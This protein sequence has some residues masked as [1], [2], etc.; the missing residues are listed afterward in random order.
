M[1]P[2]GLSM[3]CNF[4]FLI[5]LLCTCGKWYLPSYVHLFALKWYRCCRTLRLNICT[6]TEIC[7][8][9][10]GNGNRDDCFTQRII[11]SMNRLL[12]TEL[13]WILYK[14]INISIEIMQQD[15]N[16]F[17]IIH[18]CGEIYSLRVSIRLGRRRRLIYFMD[19]MFSV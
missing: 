1:D 4:V 12:R 5:V 14:H 10:N 6:G 16:G 8:C 3:N 15:Q 13:A 7:Y 11:K 17:N 18:F 9:W 19:F 2:I